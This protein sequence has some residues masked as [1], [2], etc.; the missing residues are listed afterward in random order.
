M[1]DLKKSYSY[2]TLAGDSKL[3]TEGIF[4]INKC[5]TTDK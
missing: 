2:N 4:L 1:I 5:F 3:N